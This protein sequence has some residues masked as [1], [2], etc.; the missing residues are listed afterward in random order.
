MRQ[1]KGALRERAFVFF[2]GDVARRLRKNLLTGKLTLRL[3]AQPEVALM[4]NWQFCPLA[5]G[6]TIR[7][8]YRFQEEDH[9]FVVRLD[10]ADTCFGGKKFA[11]GSCVPIV[12][13]G[14]TTCTCPS[15]QATKVISC[16]GSAGALTTSHTCG[17]REHRCLL[18][19]G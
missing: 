15:T 13:N 2:S 6:P 17:Q 18:Y 4:V 3:K 11:G 12:S 16:V 7:V 19:R 9:S 5:D 14:E 1:Y 8:Y 10:A